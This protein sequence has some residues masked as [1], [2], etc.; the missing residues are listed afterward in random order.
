VEK[1]LEAFE[2]GDGAK[3]GISDLYDDKAK[4]LTKALKSKKDFT[5]GWFGSKK[6]IVSGN[7]TR[8]GDV[9]SVKVSVSDDFDTEGLGEVFFIEPKNKGTSLAQV[10]KALDEA[11]QKA[12]ENQQ[13]NSIVRLWS[14]HTPKGNWVETYVQCIGEYEW[15]Y[16]SPPGDNYHEWGWQHDGA[17]LTQKTRDKMEEAFFEL[18]HSSEEEVKAKVGRYT[19]RGTLA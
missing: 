2:N 3:W 6:E 9:L 18:G 11:W 5:T 7:V 13:E 17:R 16:D 12:T 1:R 15:A 8:T 4:A 10:K 14:I 19:L